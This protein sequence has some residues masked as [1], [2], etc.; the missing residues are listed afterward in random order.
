MN[1]VIKDRQS[2]MPLLRCELPEG[3]VSQGQMSFVRFPENQVIHVEARADKDGCT[4]AY[5]TGET[6]LYEK[7]KVP[8]P[9]LYYA[10][11]NRKQNDSG[12][13]FSE[14]TSL[15]SDL[16]KAASVILNK[17]VEGKDYYGLSE[18]AYVKAK[19]DFDKTISQLCEELTFGQSVSSIPIANVF[20][21]YLLDGGMGI[22]ENG[23][24]IV[25]VYLCRIGAEV[26]FVQG[27][28][29]YENISKEAF[30]KAAVD[31]G[32]MASSASWSIPYIAYMISNDARDLAV[33]MKYVD[34]LEK[35]DELIEQIEQN[36]V[37]VL[38]YQQQK[39]RMETMR[40]QAM[41]NTLFAQQQQQFAAMDRIS[42][43]IHQDLDSFHNNLNQQM[44]QND[45]R[46]NAGQSGAESMDDRIQ[47]MRHESIMD[48]ETYERNDG[49]TVEYSSYADRVFENNLDTT[50]HFGTHHYYDDYIPEGWNELKKK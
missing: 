41:W 17:N 8:D 34:S 49:S 24:K 42:S 22:Y 38:Q 9:V 16:D 1:T 2:G 26:D 23:D 14:V 40:N 20:R 43:A 36:R 47:R 18:S 30:G 37:Q 50:Q 46:F 39:A 35:S 29:I 44:A 31:P 7:K 25:A 10:A 21:N 48:V 6:Y 32:V 11:Q 12:A 4:I 15:K 3:F 5:Q 28:G 13:W 45:R 19:K 27:Q 33:F